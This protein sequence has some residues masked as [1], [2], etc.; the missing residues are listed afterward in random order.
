MSSTLDTGPLSSDRSVS[1]DRF[2]QVCVRGCA[3]PA[4]RPGSA[5]ETDWR[6]CRHLADGGV[7]AKE[8]VQGLPGLFTHPPGKI[9]KELCLLLLF[10]HASGKQNDFQ[11]KMSNDQLFFPTPA[12]RNILPQKNILYIF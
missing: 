2:S 1:S 10:T 9:G 3:S 4:D 5:G 8:G 11:L 7:E 12:G 6:Q